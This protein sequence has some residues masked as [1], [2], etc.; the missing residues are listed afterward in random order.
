ML[1]DTKTTNQ[2]YYNEPDWT[3]IRD[4]L[5]YLTN[6]GHRVWWGE[7]WGDP[8]Q[9]NFLRCFGSS[10]YHLI[11]GLTKGDHSPAIDRQL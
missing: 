1:D 7:F 6:L 10:A 5:I 4:E 2:T 9:E 11:H 3:R 8:A